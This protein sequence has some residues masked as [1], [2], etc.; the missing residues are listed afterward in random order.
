MTF[1]LSALSSDDLRQLELLG[2]MVS[3]TDESLSRAVSLR[4]LSA[5]LGLQDRH[6][7]I[8][9]DLEALHE[10][11]FVIHSPRLAGE[12]SSRLTA[13]GLDHWRAFDA[14]R[15]K[16]SA[17]R[18]PLRD[19]YLR[20]LY[21]RI[22]DHDTH[23]NREDYLATAPSCLGVEYTADDI[24][25][26]GSWL[27]ESGFIA[28]EGSWGNP[29][30]M[31]PTLTP[32]GIFVVEHNRSVSDP[33]SASGPSTTYNSTFNAP[34]NVAQGSSDVHQ[35]M[36]ID[37]WQERTTQIADAVQ[38]AL[39][40]LNPSIREEAAEQVAQLRAELDGA[41]DP[42]RVRSILESMVE[43]FSKTTAGALGGALVAQ[44]SGLLPQ[45]PS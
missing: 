29:S 19:A 23:P 1:S 25:K 38:Q 44:L 2:A 40:A 11:R 26:A 43:T 27:R 41:S 34:A 7:S 35:K 36:T 9:S 33:P 30:P 21:E 31:W 6:E 24:S 4:P 8:R 17:R 20:W 37:A 13:A 28:G 39:P 10:R 15:S 42:P 5:E 3:L 22:E 18:I 16:P 12:F 32:K 45:L 14:A